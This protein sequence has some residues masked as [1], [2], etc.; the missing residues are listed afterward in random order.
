MCYR[1][2]IGDDVNGSD[3]GYK[4]HLIYNLIA[5][6]KDKP[7][8]TESNSPSPI[9]FEWNVTAIP[10]EVPGFLPTASIIINSLDVDPW[11][12][13]EIETVLYGDEDSDAALM[14]MTELMTFL[15]EWARVQIID[16]GD[17]TWT[18]IAAR[19]GFI[20]V[21]EEGLF[22]IVDVEATYLDAETYEISDT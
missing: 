4:L 19:D 15:D 12:L 8:S 3:S 18:A 21:D 20:T 6:P 22:T 13:E 11:L 17:G 1:T 14:S 16:N 5:V 7:Y 2:K 9:E 10:E